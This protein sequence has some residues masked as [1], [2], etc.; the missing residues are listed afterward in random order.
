M[1]PEVWDDR[2]YTWSADVWA[3]GCTAYELCAVTA[4]LRGSVVA[5]LGSGRAVWK[6]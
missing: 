4:A 1:A 3:L 2:P 6:V 5:G